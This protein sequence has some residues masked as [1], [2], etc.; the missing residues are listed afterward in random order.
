MMPPP[1]TADA[2]LEL[3]RAYQPAA[4]LAAAADLDLFSALAPTPCAATALAA[5]LKVDPRGLTMLLD[6]LVALELLEKTDNRYRVPEDVA[7]LLA[8][9]GKG[10]VLAMAQ[11]QVNCLRRWAQLATVVQTGQPAER[12]PGVRG[13]QGDL[14]SFIGAM[15]NVSAPRADEVI[16]SIDPLQFQHLL[17]IGGGPGTWTMAFLRACPT[18]R[19]TLYDLPD[20]IPLARERLA[21]AGLLDRVNLAAGDFSQDPLPRAADLAWVSAIVHQNSRAENRA[22][23][24]KIYQALVPG[25]RI[26]I[27]DLIMDESRTQPVAGALFAINMLV[28]TNSGGTFTFAE[29]R[30]DLES[31]GFTGVTVARNDGTMSAVVTARRR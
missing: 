13:E 10:S 15:H 9:H 12:S 4:V 25:G 31:A 20:V 8:H 21:A 23:F 5:A 22:L 28:A 3:G 30:E 1:W 7:A 29:L 14:A 27:R 2:V 6:A 18:A 24:A 11:H 17:D 19:A 26:A 16:S